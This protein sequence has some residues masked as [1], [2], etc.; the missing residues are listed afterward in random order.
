[1]AGTMYYDRRVPEGLL[2]TIRPGGALSWLVAWVRSEE[3][4][5]ILA[6][7]QLRRQRSGACLQLYLGS[8]SV[9]SIHLARG[10]VRFR[11]TQRYVEVMPDLFSRTHDQDELVKPATRDSIQQ[12]LRQIPSRV[13][14]KY[15]KAES[16][17]HGGFM[18]R[19]ALEHRPDDACLVV[20]RE[21]TIGYG[22]IDE[23][24]SIRLELEASLPS[25]LGENHTELDAIALLPAGEIAIIE[26]KDLASTE[27]LATAACQ[28][29]A[30]VLRFT[31]LDAK[32]ASWRESLRGLSE[33]KVWAGLL[34]TAGQL[35]EN[36]RLVPIIAATDEQP[37]K[38][39]DRW[40]A[41]IRPT[42]T[43]HATALSNLRLWRLS[44][45]GHLQDEASL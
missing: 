7:L 6:D 3:G 23:R 22:S 26:L 31:I 32:Q 39:A 28:A 16:Q 20:D 4:A 10:K 34:P 19:Y 27:A 37:V 11:A 14:G 24:K 29:A 42:A 8:T 40:R 21:V 43:A 2:E 44:R 30:H 25:S 36:A 45:N 18:R 12:Y 5:G 41:A 13:A 1:M 35:A 33:Q 9:L 15:F 17:V 38:W